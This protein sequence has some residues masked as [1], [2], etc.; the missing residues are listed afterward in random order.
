MLSDCRDLAMADQH[1]CADTTVLLERLLK[2]FQSEAFSMEHD[3][4][5]FTQD[6]VADGVP[7]LKL[8]SC[9]LGEV[10]S[11][12]DQFPARESAILLD[13]AESSSPDIEITEELCGSASIEPLIE[14]SR[15]P[16][17]RCDIALPF[18]NA[19]I[20]APLSSGAHPTCSGDLEPEYSGTREDAFQWFR[21]FCNNLRDNRFGINFMDRVVA[22]L[23]QH[24]GTRIWHNFS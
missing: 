3:H 21:H 17:L 6:Q 23:K 4:F 9:L 24:V 20:Q 11:V 8:R 12:K 10:V 7:G 15:D 13:R 1:A 14:A 19:N 18:C 2:Q 22:S 16:Q 5:A